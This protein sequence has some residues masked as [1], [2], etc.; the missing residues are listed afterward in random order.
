MPA[1]YTGVPRHAPLGSTSKV[2]DNVIDLPGSAGR[3]R[4]AGIA[5]SLAL[6]IVVVVAAPASSQTTTPST[7]QPAT[8]PAT[9][10]PAKPNIGQ[11]LV[12]EPLARGGGGARGPFVTDPVEVALDRKSTRLNFSDSSTS[13]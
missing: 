7:T 10:E 2:R 6:L 8:R 13:Y 4:L 1:P 9:T 3:A 11:C 12:I 5:A